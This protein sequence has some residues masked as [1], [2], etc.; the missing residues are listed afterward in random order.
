MKGRAIIP[1]VLGLCV[2]LIAVKYLANTLQNAKGSTG[3][4]QAIAVVRATRDIDGSQE[5]T[6]DL[7]ELVETT[8]ETLV[9][10][11]ER[12]SSIDDVVGRVTAKPIPERAPVLQS[13]LAPPGTP[14]G[15]VGKIPDGFRAV[16]VKIDEVT[17]VAYQLRPGSWV[18]VIVVMDII[19]GTGRSGKET[20]AEVILQ[21]VQVA[22]I[23]GATSAGADRRSSKVKPAKSVT[24]LVREQDVPKLHLAATRGKVTLALRGEDEQRTDK[25]ASARE[26]EVFATHLKPDRG[27]GDGASIS[28]KVAMA[29]SRTRQQARTRPR[30]PEPPHSLVVYRGS[31]Q[32]DPLTVEQIT[33]ANAHSRTVV[34]IGRG[35]V[36][37]TGHSQLDNELGTGASKA[38]S[39]DEKEYR[40]RQRYPSGSEN[41]E[42]E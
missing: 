15:M 14:P 25:P 28:S 35:P 20:I 40:H 2:G 18:D 1:L 17:G 41:T 8:D 3:E 19:T 11:R 12:V 24:L 23:G 34:G 21:H 6:P 36:S 27:K 30:I 4:Q 33:F 13:M 39:Y 26:S 32:G 5:I 22:A 38:G 16:S 7:V 42:V 31:T 29:D 9:P 10:A 37:R